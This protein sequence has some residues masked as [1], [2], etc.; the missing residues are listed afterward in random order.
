MGEPGGGQDEEGGAC[1]E[2]MLAEFR[3]G[4]R[5]NRRRGDEMVV[6]EI[7]ADGVGRCVYYRSLLF[8][9]FLL[10]RR[11]FS[12]SFSS[13]T[14][15]TRRRNSSNFL[16]PE[17]QNTRSKPLGRFLRPHLIR[18]IKIGFPIMRDNFPQ[19]VNSNSRIIRRQR[20]IILSRA[21]IQHCRFER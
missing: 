2:D 21:K 7:H 17:P 1:V 3:G 19:R 13:P 11:S 15:Y 10:R 20:I 16:I 14:V 9:L 6:V 12:S 18:I 5:W 4:G 8:L